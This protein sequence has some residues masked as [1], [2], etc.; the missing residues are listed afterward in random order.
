ML[1][2]DRVDG[3]CR[4]LLEVVSNVIEED[5]NHNLLTTDHVPSTSHI[6]W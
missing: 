2:G 6:L 4:D 1:T 5:Q 3:K